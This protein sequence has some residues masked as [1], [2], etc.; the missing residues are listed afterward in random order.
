MRAQGREWLDLRALTQYAS[1]SQRTIRE[2]IHRSGNPLPAAQV[3]KNSRPLKGLKSAAAL[4]NWTV[5]C[6]L[7]LE[8]QRLEP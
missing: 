1:V 4:F 8:I 2:W 3:G 7:S 5:E 6:G